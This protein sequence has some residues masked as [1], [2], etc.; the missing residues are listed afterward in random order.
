MTHYQALELS[1]DA[2]ADD[3]RRAYRRLVLLTHPDRTPDP[4]AHARYLIVNAAYETLSDPGRRQAYDNGLRA[5][6]AVPTTASS[7][8]KARDPYRRSAAAPRSTAATNHAAGS[9]QGIY[10]RYAGMGR[11]VCQ[12]LLV[13]SLLLG[14]DRTWVLTFPRERVLSCTFYSRSKG[15]SF[16]VSVTPNANFRVCVK[17]A[18]VLGLRRT[19]LFE[20]VLSYGYLTADGKVDFEEHQ[21]DSIHG[22]LGSVFLLAM[23]ATAA[24]GAWP[25]P[26][27]RR[28]VDCAVTGG[29]L[30][31]I[32]GWLF[33]MY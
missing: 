33:S 2:T 19:A 30:A 27:A 12:L 23:L 29:I 3:I 21:V 14:I 5:P 4:A 7:P 10:L 16:C 20:Q 11:L 18:E 32:I 15:M 17:E 24:V 6:T 26:A 28:Q 22:N 1:A 13:F 25:G 31:V 9:Y 8:G